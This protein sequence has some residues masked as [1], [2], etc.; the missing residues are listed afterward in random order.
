MLP[1]KKK[2]ATT[3]SPKRGY[4]VHLSPAGCTLPPCGGSWVLARDCRHTIAAVVA[5]AGSWLGFRAGQ[6]MCRRPR[7]GVTGVNSPGPAPS[8]PC[9]KQG[10]N[11]PT[12]APS[13]AWLR[14]GETEAQVPSPGQGVKADGLVP[15]QPVNTPSPAPPPAIISGLRAQSRPGQ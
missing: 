12:N 15:P 9:A 7:A 11:W 1:I 10:G 14:V 5:G 13:L 2:K 6:S 8:P 3:T 4:K